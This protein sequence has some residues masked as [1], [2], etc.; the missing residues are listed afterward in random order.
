MLKKHGFISKPP[1][2]T[3]NLGVQSG[4]A[5]F[6]DFSIF[7]NSKKPGAYYLQYNPHLFAQ[8]I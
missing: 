7:S 1:I 5:P 6:H 4:L 2:S 8:L 3:Q